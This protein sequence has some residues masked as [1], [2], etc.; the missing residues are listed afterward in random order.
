MHARIRKGGRVGEKKGK[1]A[2]RLGPKDIAHVS[3]GPIKYFLMY[4]KPP[5]IKLPRQ[6]SNDPFFLGLMSVAMLF[7][8]LIVP[9]IYLTQD[10]RKDDPDDDIWSVVNL[11]EKQEKPKPVEPPKPQKPKQQIAEAQKPEV[12]P[13]PPKPVVKPPKP[14]EPKKAPQKI[15]ET[16]KQKRKVEK[17]VAKP[18]KTLTQAEVPK[19][20]G[21]KR[22]ADA[23]KSAGVVTTGAKKPDFKAPGKVRPGQKV[24]LAGGERGG[25]KFRPDAGGARKGKTNADVKGVEGGVPNKASGVNLSKLGLGAGKILSK[26]GAG[27]IRTNFKSSAGGVGGGSGSASKTYGLGGPGSG[28]RL[29]VSGA[30]GAVNN[31]GGFG[32]NGSGAGGSGGLGSGAL[33]G[34]FGRNGGSGGRADVAVPA[35]DPVVSGGLTAQEVAAVIRANLNQIRHCYE[36]LLQ[37]SP[38]AAGKIKVNFNVVASGRVGSVAIVESSIRDSIMKGCVTGKVRRWKFPKP[39]GGLAVD[40]NYPF[41]FNPL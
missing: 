18:T 22:L 8:F 26:T 38:N 33:G 11:P 29:G 31:F 2:I 41:V 6:Q 39:R 34:G 30:G 4:V 40:V 20:P 37:R 35:G 7:Y 10:N 19:K 25:G 16:P 15:V 12:K 5:V 1:G 24:G 3:C 13:K 36:Q 28:R 14:I 9:A 17:P 21:L 23:V 32:G 27:A